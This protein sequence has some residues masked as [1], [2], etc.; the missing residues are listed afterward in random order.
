MRAAFR[1][2]NNLVDNSLFGEMLRSETQTF[3]GTIRLA[4]VFPENRGT[5]FGTDNGIDRVFQH[6]HLIADSDRE[7]PSGSSLANHGYDNRHFDLCHLSEIEGDCFGLS[8]FFGVDTGICAGC[9][10]ERKYRAAEL[11]A[12]F[13][14]AEGFSIP[15]RFR[16]A[17]VSVTALFRVATFLMAHDDYRQAMKTR[18]AADDGRIFR[19]SFIA[20][21]L[22]EVF[23]Q[24]FD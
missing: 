21:K 3:G 5:P 20:V 6:Q 9:I 16:H 2:L 7:C 18:H 11:F 8:A 13:H 14:H 12:Q 19:K 24:A 10:D 22:D 23:K 1:F 15:L 17:E 4:R